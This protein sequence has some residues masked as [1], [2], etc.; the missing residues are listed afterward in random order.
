MTD[1]S[2]PALAK[3]IGRAKELAPHM[4]GKVETMQCDVTKEFDVQA[5]VEK[6]DAWGGLDVMFNNAGIMHADDAG[7]VPN[8][9]VSRQFVFITPLKHNYDRC[10][11][12]SRENLGS[13]SEHQR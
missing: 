2:E 10:D 7:I 12:H 1:I 6:L 5:I 9:P 4:T 13:H 3:A 11:R 8:P